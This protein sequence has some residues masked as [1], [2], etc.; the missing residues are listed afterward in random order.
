MKRKEQI[1]KK[2]QGVIQEIVDDHDRPILNMSVA[3]SARLGFNYT[4]LSNVFSCV[5]NITIEHYFINCKIDKA[6][7]LLKDKDISIQDIAQRLHYCS[8]A[9]FS[10]QFKT[11]TGQCPSEYRKQCL[12]P[13]MTD[14]SVP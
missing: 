1:A 3:I 2:I 10:S 11:V 9:H 4:Y 7:R 5:K 14:H 8:K 12:M 6:K 13:A